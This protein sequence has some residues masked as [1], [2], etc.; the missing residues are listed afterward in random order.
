MNY[1]VTVLLA[2]TC[3]CIGQIYVPP[4]LLFIVANTLFNVG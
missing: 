4:Y 3:S 2:S 1:K